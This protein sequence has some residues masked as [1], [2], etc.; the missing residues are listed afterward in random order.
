MSNGFVQPLGSCLLTY[1]YNPWCLCYL[2]WSRDYATYPML[3]NWA[4]IVYDVQQNTDVSIFQSEKGSHVDFMIFLL[5]IP[6]QSRFI[7]F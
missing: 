2:W 1:E 7:L 5:T 4:S 6:I 3:R